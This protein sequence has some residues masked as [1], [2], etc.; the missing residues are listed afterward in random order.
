MSKIALITGGNRGLGRAIAIALA[1]AGPDVVI[2]YRSHA[3][4]VAEVVAELEGKGRRAAALQLD[5]TQVAAFPAFAAQLRETLQTTWGR[6]SFDHLVNNAGFSGATVIGETEEETL[7]RLFLVHYKGVY[8]LTQ[9]L[10]TTQDGVS[11]LLAD[12]CRIVNLSS[13]LARFVTK[14]YAVYASMKGAVEVLTRYWALE[15]GERGISVNTIAPGPVATDF[16]GGYLRASEE[17]RTR[18][19]GMTA[20]GRTATATDIGPAVAALLADGTGWIT[21]QRIEA[22]GDFRL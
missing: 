10:A 7:D 21:A 4:E 14:P 3:D 5:T 2:T 19:G 13:G 20:L 12:G 15:L 6:D 17:I 16:A 18:M 22:S 8:L 1:D 11:P 9:A